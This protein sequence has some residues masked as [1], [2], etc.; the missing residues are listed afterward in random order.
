MIKNYFMVGLVGILLASTQ[1]FATPPTFLTFTDGQDVEVP[2]SLLRKAAKSEL[3]PKIHPG[4]HRFEVWRRTLTPEKN[5]TRF[6]RMDFS[7]SSDTDELSNCHPDR[8]ITFYWD[9]KK[10]GWV[11]SSTVTISPATKLSK[12]LTLHWDEKKGD[13]VYS[14]TV[15]SFPVTQSLTSKKG[16]TKG[17]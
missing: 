16:T 15:T 8:L 3:S 14:P 5:M 1:I 7:Y 17:A 4:T 10:E 11:Y 2:V 6:S 9:A 12:L 13:W